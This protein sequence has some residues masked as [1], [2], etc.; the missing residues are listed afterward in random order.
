MGGSG[1]FLGPSDA[2][3]LRER[4]RDSERRDVS[5]SYESDVA[6]YLGEQLAT[7]NARDVD[8]TKEI[9]DRIRAELSD[10]V[11]TA[12]DLVFGGSVAKHTFVDGLSDIDAL[13]LV[14]AG[15]DQADSPEAL[16]SAFA[17]KLRSVFGRDTVDV[18]RLAVTLEVGDKTVQLL[19]AFRHGD[20]YRISSID[21]RS[22]SSISP[23]QFTD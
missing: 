10:E 22:W 20:G 13:V 17:D 14:K 21:G 6:D 7:Y 19:P 9:L 3:S 15:A 16:R 8:G 4:L 1:G 11:E 18:G 12:V 5:D 2:E 23:R